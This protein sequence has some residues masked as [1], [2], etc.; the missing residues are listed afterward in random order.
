MDM[1]ECKGNMKGRHKDENYS[2]PGRKDE[3]S[4]EDRS[5]IVR[6][7]AYSFLREGLNLGE[8]GEM[9][10]YLRKVMLERMKKKE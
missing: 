9:V 3:D 8:S 7:T 5:D 10:K 2:C 4:V 6:C 1:F